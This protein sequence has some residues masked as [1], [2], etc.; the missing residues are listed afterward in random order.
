MKLEPIKKKIK[1]IFEIFTADNDEDENEIMVAFEKHLD[2]LKGLL[3]KISDKL[4][5]EV[6]DDIEEKS[7]DKK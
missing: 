2:K 4:K 7:R 3:E 5:K 6:E 1:S